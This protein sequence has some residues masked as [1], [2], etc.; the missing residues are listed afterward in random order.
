MKMSQ[1][2]VMP[3]K[4]AP[5]DADT[6]NHRLLVQGAFVRQLMAGVYSYLPFG[7]R[8]LT[9]IENIIREEMDA[10]GSQELL[11]PMLHPSE[12][13]KISGGWEHV[14]VLFK[15]K[16]RT[17]KDYALAQSEEEVVTPLMKEFI[18]SYKDLPKSVY[19]IQ[20]K[21]RDELRSKSGI[22]RGREFL[23]KD[24]YSF[25]DNQDDFEKYYE[26]A[27]QAY[28]KIFD[29]LGLVSKVTE[30]SGGGFSEKISYE[31][32]VITDAGEARVLY[33]DECDFCV[34]VDDITKYSEGDK[35]PKCGKDTLE[36]AT[37]S[38]VGNVFDLGQKYSKSFDMSYVDREG[39]RKYPI[40]GCYGIGITRTM[41]VVVE[42]Y[43]DD[44]G[45]IWPKNIAP[46]QVS[47]ISLRETGKQAE[48]I[49]RNMT[50]AGIEVLWDDRDTGTGV[51]F[52][53]ADLIGN[54]Y[55][56]VVSQR[57][58][59]AGGVEIKERNS[60]LTRIVKAEEALSLINN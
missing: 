36:P 58:Q 33:C 20:W 35:C 25:H 49:Y 43:H 52:A 44:K 50:K 41:G 28:I 59:D 19:H 1:I 54:P 37:A 10:I 47:L 42:K 21:F 29:R 60:E 8:V 32:E 6:V 48:E 14:D 13:W 34:N 46:Y 55:R 45:I 57:S 56:V 30:A 40:M 9:K 27:K 7:L 31:F 51:K 3:L 2:A 22:L 17:G 12:I 18:L 11:M 16:S 24:M 38:E 53:D 4:S 5:K 39:V 23:M 26:V 15:L